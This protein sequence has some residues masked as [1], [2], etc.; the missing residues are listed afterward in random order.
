MIKPLSPVSITLRMN[1]PVV[2]TRPANPRFG[3]GT[4]TS[5]PA[6]VLE[7]RKDFDSAVGSGD[8]SRQHWLVL[9]IES[10]PEADRT[11]A[12]HRAIAH[13]NDK[14]QRHAAQQI[15][16]LPEAD[17]KAAYDA[18]M[19]TNRISVQ[20][21]AI[22]Q[23]EFLPESDRKAA[24]LTAIDIRKHTQVKMWGLEQM[25]HLSQADRKAVLQVVKAMKVPGMYR[26]AEREAKSV[27]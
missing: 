11:V 17:R 15:Q 8:S 25:R 26:F 21:L 20:Y 13:D 3:E 1:R 7:W 18:A 23:T 10:L 14:V 5:P 2:A 24:V 22:F 12:F 16:C 9:Q 27:S 4:F 19:A 6:N